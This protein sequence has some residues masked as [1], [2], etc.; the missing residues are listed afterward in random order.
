MLVRVAIVY[1]Q[2]RV[3]DLPSKAGNARH[4]RTSASCS[5]SSASCTDPRIR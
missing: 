5:A 4:A 1:S 3:V 2:R